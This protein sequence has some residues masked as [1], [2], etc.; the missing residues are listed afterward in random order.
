MNKDF[1]FFD[2]RQKYLLFVTTTNE[3]NK[4][5]EKISIPVIGIGAGRYV[6]G[7]VL[8]WSDMLGFFEDFKPKF[9][10]QYLQGAKLTKNA[11]QQFADEVRNGLFPETK[12]IY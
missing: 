12:N 4:I 1:R 5:A 11:V 3:K 7:Q 8:V 10:K 9:V 6:D 2:S